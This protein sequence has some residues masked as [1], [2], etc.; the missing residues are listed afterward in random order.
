MFSSVPPRLPGSGLRR[1]LGAAL[2]TAGLTIGLL[3]ATGPTS[4]QAEDADITCTASQNIFAIKTNGELWLYQ[5][6][7]LSNKDASP[8]WN[9]VPKVL[10]T[11]WN[12]FAKLLAGPDGWLY[13]IK[14]VANGGG[15]FAY[16]WNGTKFD[17]AGKAIGSIFN[18]WTDPSHLNKITIDARGDFYLI[19]DN[20]NL[21]RY[22]YSAATNTFTASQPMGSG[23]NVFDSITAAGD[24]VIYGRTP[25]GALHRYQF[26][27]VSDRYIHHVQNGASGW[28]AFT[29]LLSVGGDTILGIESSGQLS[30]YRYK[31]DPG[32]WLFQHE[33]LS[34]GFQDYTNVVGTANACKLTASYVPPAPAVPTESNAP[35][36]VTQTSGSQLEYGYS[37]NI[38]RAFWGHQADP[39]D[40]GGVVWTPFNGTSAYTG[41]PALTEGADSKVELTFHDVNARFSTRIQ[42]AAGSTGLG[43]VVDRAG[44]MASSTVAAKAAVNGKVVLFAVDGNGQIW[45]KPEQELGYLPW[46]AYTSPVL[47]GV[48]AVSPGPG[49][50]VTVIARDTA[51][52]FWAASWNGTGLSAFTS[53]GGSGFTGKVSV[54]RYPGD[55][56]RV[57]A[58]DSEGHIKTQKQTTAGTA[59][60][61]TWQTVGDES[62]TWPGLPA[63]VM[64]PDTGLIEVLVRGADGKNYFSQEQAQGAGLWPTWKAIVLTVDEQ[65][66]TD[67]TPLV[68]KDS[69]VDKWAFATYTQDFALR[70]ITGQ[71]ATSANAKTAAGAKKRAGEQVGDPVFTRHVL[72]QPPK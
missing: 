57:F 53:L 38:G 5:Y 10:G 2:L 63:A 41:T 36:A 11:G 58:R 47:S 3:A 14:S 52:T 48:P 35:I 71:S 31:R 26:E 30:Q 55:L 9:A 54:V 62:Q 44:L 59:F 23:F 70:L 28:Q 7:D 24:G 45:A 56:L 61:G 40:F 69:G 67:P 18:G 72:P 6:N 13:G 8:V 46:R 66:A 21:R 50:T 49:G 20:G 43:P 19:L 37:D 68:Y 42:T 65:Y 12:M 64:A 25:A 33:P 39:A 34:T 4:A 1:K 60:P 22:E 16:H 27:R 51:G 17:V 29:K 32:Q 15:M